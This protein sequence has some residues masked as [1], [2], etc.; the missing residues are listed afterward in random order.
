MDPKGFTDIVNNIS[1]YTDPFIFA[2]LLL[3]ELWVLFRLR[4]KIDASGLLT[5]ILHLVAS[6]IRF[7]RSYYEKLESLLIVAGYIIWVSLYYFTFEMEFIKI[8]LKS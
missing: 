3:V 7:L 2:A 6:M 1:K 4:F 5:L 8:T